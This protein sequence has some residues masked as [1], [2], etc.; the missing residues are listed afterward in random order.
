MDLAAAKH[1]IVELVA[2][3]GTQI[4]IRCFTTLTIDYDP[5]HKRKTR[6][7]GDRLNARLHQETL[8]ELKVDKQ[9]LLLS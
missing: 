8:S 1:L 5:G 2:Q 3:S 7:Q 6:R 4:I 9:K